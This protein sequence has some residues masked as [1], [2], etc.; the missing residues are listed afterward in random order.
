MENLD[1]D[2]I[3][4]DVEDEIFKAVINKHSNNDE[5]YQKGGI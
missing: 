1:Y 2:L 4:D 5:S 3:S